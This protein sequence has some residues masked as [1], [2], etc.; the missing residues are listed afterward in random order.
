MVTGFKETLFVIQTKKGIAVQ[1]IPYD[2]EFC[3]EM[4][5]IAESLYKSTF[6][7]EYLEA[8]YIKGLEI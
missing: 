2:Q 4:V 3:E 1:N 8:K 6:I 5:S 7:E